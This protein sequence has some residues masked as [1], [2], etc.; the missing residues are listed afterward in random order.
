MH[1]DFTGTS[2]MA[3]DCQVLQLMDGHEPLADHA[4]IDLRTADHSDDGS[5][6]LET[7]TPDMQI[8]DANIARPLNEILNFLG[9]VV[10]GRIKED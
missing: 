9:N 10:V 2:S 1:G 7:D 6:S 8:D 3:F 4:C 5:M